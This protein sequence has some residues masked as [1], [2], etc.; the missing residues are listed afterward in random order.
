[1]NMRTKLLWDILIGLSVLSAGGVGY[2]LYQID[3][4]SKEARY[5][6]ESEQIGTD[7]DLQDKV[8]ALENT[9]AERDAFKFRV[10]NNPVDLGNVIALDGAGYSQRR[11]N[12]WVTGIVTGSEPKALV[13]FKN[14]NYELTVGDS[15]AGGIIRRISTTD[16]IFEKDDVTTIFE[17][18]L[19]KSR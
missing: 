19:I 10:K 6:Y 4:L 18:G 16:V 15:I 3:Q 1:M 2:Q 9:L 13:Q 5:N 17:L 8:S 7:Q 11:R 14:M 12:L